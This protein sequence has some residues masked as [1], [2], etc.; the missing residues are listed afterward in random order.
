MGR[1]GGGRDNRSHAEYKVQSQMSVPCDFIYL[2]HHFS[3]DAELCAESCVKFFA[4]CMAFLLSHHAAVKKTAANA[5][6][7]GE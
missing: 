7:V 6:K 3:L 4:S 2:I 1:R 5:M